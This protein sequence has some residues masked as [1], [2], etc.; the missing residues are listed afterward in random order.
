MSKRRKRTFTRQRKS[1][2]QKALTLAKKNKKALKGENKSSVGAFSAEAQI[3]DTVGNIYRMCL[4]AQGDDYHERIG[5]E[6]ILRLLQVRFSLKTHANDTDSITTIMIFKY[7]DMDSLLPTM[8]GT[9]AT[10]VLVS[11]S[12]LSLLHLTNKHRYRVLYREEF[13]GN[14][15]G[16]ENWVRK[17]TLKLNNKCSYDGPVDE[18]Q[19]KGSIYMG[20]YTDSA[21]NNTPNFEFKSL[22]KYTEA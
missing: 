9:P 19:A 20:V 15:D 3:T 21:V 4:V 11:A 22:L 7:V 2:A 8:V 5:R 16:R 10:D 13:I 18:D 17:V 6:I 14:P 1:V 12:P